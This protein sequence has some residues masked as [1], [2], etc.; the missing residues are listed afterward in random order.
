[1]NSPAIQTVI[2]DLGKTL[3]PFSLAPLHA[4]LDAQPGSREAAK[5]LFQ[6]FECGDL[7]PE[8]F[9]DAVCGLANLSAPEFG[10][11]WNSIFEPHLLVPE[12]WLRFLLRRYRCGLLSNTNALH[13]AFLLSEQPVLAEFAFRILSHEVG[14]AK[15]DPLIFEAAE[16][17]ARC[18]P[19]SILYFDDIP[20]FVA[21]ARRRGWQAH[22][23]TA[24]QA[25][26]SV[27]PE[28][29]S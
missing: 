28:L 12:S 9:Q 27:L 10:P 7:E 16:A 8:A 14:A 5:H 3:I 23:F 13:F 24:A 22:Q 18:R 25:V 1:M 15:P 6:R 2:F 17:A 19:E 26:S 20:E 4:R 11:W 29:S 21:A